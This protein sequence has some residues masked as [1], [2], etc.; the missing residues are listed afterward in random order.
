ML[1]VII[2]IKT[3]SC[4]LPSPLVDIFVMHIGRFLIMHC[5]H[6]RSRHTTNTSCFIQKKGPDFFTPPQTEAREYYMLTYMHTRTKDFHA[7]EFIHILLGFHEKPQN[8]SSNLL[9]CLLVGWLVITATIRNN[10]TLL[11]VYCFMLMW[12]RKMVFDFCVRGMISRI[13]PRL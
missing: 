1:T 4:Y 9:Q 2:W 8:I 10:D 7:H 12:V 3:F 6:K 13:L 11:R 5:K